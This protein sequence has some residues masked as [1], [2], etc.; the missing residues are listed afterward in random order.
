MKRKL[1]VGGRGP[2]RIKARMDADPRRSRMSQIRLVAGPKLTGSIIV[3][4]SDNRRA[5]AA[6]TAYHELA[7]DFTPRMGVYRLGDMGV[8][9]WDKTISVG[10]FPS[11]DCQHRHLLD[12]FI[13][14]LERR[15]G[16]SLE[17]AA[18]S[19]RDTGNS[20]VHV[21]LRDPRE[22]NLSKW[23]LDRLERAVQ[24]AAREVYSRIR[25]EQREYM[26]EREP[27]RPDRER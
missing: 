2:I 8:D 5:P 12:T 27:E 16:K 14:A 23:S 22:G 19:H 10:L 1:E 13:P 25:E 24:D 7:D 26:R 15:L 21:T 20:H 9:S 6:S 4:V 18:W 11:H 17:W 3:S